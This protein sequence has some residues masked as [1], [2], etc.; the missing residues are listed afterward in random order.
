M[1]ATRGYFATR[2]GNDIGDF[3]LAPSSLGRGDAKVIPN[4][5]DMYA[6][7]DRGAHQSGTAPMKFGTALWTGAKAW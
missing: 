5:T 4:V 1:R 2:T 3:T 7:P 6:A